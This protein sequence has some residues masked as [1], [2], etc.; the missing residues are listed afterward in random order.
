R[1]FGALVRQRVK[2]VLRDLSR[3]EKRVRIVLSDL[4]LVISQ[5]GKKRFRL[6]PNRDYFSKTRNRAHSLR[7][8]PVLRLLV[9]LVGRRNTL[10]MSAHVQLQKYA[11]TWIQEK[12]PTSPQDEPRKAPSPLQQKET[13]PE[14]P[15]IPPI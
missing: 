12:P 14:R 6:F 9:I 2:P 1:I 7:D 4:V 11:N 13:E 15:V 5:F 3:L 10:T 8:Q